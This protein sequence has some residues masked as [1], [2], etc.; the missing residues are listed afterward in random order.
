MRLYEL[1]SPE[2]KNTKKAVDY[3]DEPNNNKRYRADHKPIGG[4]ALS[5]VQV[6]PRNQQ[7]VIKTQEEP[8]EDRYMDGFRVWAEVTAR[9]AKDCRFFPKIYGV[10]DRQDSSGR[11]QPRYRMEQLQSWRVANTKLLAHIYESTFDE[12]SFLNRLDEFSQQFN[13]GKNSLDETILDKIDTLT[14][15]SASS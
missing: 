13:P 6:D 8:D 10:D 7:D 9:Y 2:F 11:Y 15:L 14:G 3:V 5:T 1:I 12:D 4:G